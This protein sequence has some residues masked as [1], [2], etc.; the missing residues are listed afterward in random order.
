MIV[1]L[2]LILLR[3]HHI[4]FLVV[5]FFRGKNLLSTKMLPT[6][7][8]GISGKNA[9]NP[10]KYTTGGYLRTKSSMK[11]AFVHGVVSI[12]IFQPTHP[13]TMDTYDL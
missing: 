8:S 9:S 2:Y 3:S 7:K 10:W 5:V 6:E 4:G 12:Q 1:S 13:L 11:I